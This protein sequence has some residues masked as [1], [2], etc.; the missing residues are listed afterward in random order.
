MTPIA[1]DPVTRV[2]GQLRVEV[3]LDGGAVSHAWVSSTMLRGFESLLVG[4][5]PRDAWLMAQR[6]C[7]TCTGVHA[8]A[9]VR[10]VERALVI[11]VPKNARLIR[12]ILGG[13]M[14]VRDHVMAFYQKAL[15]DWVD[16]QSAST[17]DPVA[18][19]RL[20]ADTSPW[21]ANSSAY[22]TDVRTRIDALLRSG[23]PG[24]FGGDWWG[25]PAYR[26]SPEQNLLLVA[27]MLEALEWQ[28][29][30]LRIEALLGGKDP[31][32]QTYL[33]GGMSVAPP[34]GGPAAAKNR[35]HPQVPDRNAP[36]ALSTEGLDLMSSIIG[37]AKTF[38]D[39]V[40]TPDVMLLARAYP[41]DLTRGGGV[42]SYLSFGEFPQD[43]AK[44]AQLFFPNGR[45]MEG[46]LEASQPAEEGDVAESL[47][48][49]W[50]AEPDGADGLVRPVSATLEPT[51][52]GSVPLTAL[53]GAGKYSWT[54]AARYD[55][56]PIEAGPLARALVGVANGQNEITL[57]LSTVVNELGVGVDGLRS[58]LGRHLSRAVEAEVVSRSL[59]SWIW[60][61]RSN[62]ATG[63][64]AVATNE[65]WDP[66]TWPSEAEGWSLGEG[67]RGAVAH[68]VAIK[69]G[70]IARY[71]VVDGSTWNTSPRDGLSLPGPLEKALEGIPVEDQARPIEVMRVIHSFA[72]CAACAAHVCGPAAAAG[73]GVHV[74]SREAVR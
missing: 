14:L 9:S 54:K 7:G 2:G 29:G 19:A 66:A 60:E 61:L 47:K 63:D 68:W 53:D 44:S 22:F 3:E 11:S 31:H 74:H 41:E 71:Q 15:P 30:F 28:R 46:K 51:Y 52:T 35:Q 72:P 43:E 33:V 18:T 67:P 70:R 17:A 64:V 45:L 27:H 16:V 73:P 4:R 42:S 40:L 20:A 13:T 57:A 12:N 50:Y 39:Q 38:V 25:H 1:I 56:L 5:D 37:T 48:H 23:Q 10:A 65:L 69:D 49:A 62:L 21:P 6:I 36:M 58:T 24:P 32:P 8:L 55:G 34:W 59:D 26:L